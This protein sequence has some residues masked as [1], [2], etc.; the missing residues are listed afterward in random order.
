MSANPPSSGV[1][2]PR[3]ASP[4]S[5]DMT[6]SDSKWDSWWKPGAAGPDMGQRHQPR[7]KPR[8]TDSEHTNRAAR[9]KRE[10][11]GSGLGKSKRPTPFAWQ[12]CAKAVYKSAFYDST[13]LP[14]VHAFLQHVLFE[15]QQI[16]W[17]ALNPASYCVAH[18]GAVVHVCF[19]TCHC[20]RASGERSTDEG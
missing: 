19:V 8:T 2:R 6:L 7:V 3:D 13:V 18:F 1:K 5:D 4:R 20:A 16:P 14:A 9:W 17:Y 11:S 12:R 15:R 10:R